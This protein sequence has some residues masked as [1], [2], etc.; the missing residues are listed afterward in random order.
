VSVPELVIDTNVVLDA[1]AFRHPSV[2]GIAAAV[3]QQRLRW[4]AT[5]AMLDELRWVLAH[6]PHDRWRPSFERALTCF[7][8]GPALVVDEPTLGGGQRLHCTDPDDQ[9]FIDLALAW[10]ATALLT[11]DRALLRLARRARLRGVVVATPEAWCPG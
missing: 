8:G 7:V 9:K 5:A 3:E 4:I 6:P 1:W 2:A 10:P 11:R